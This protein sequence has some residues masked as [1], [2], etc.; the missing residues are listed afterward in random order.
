MVTALFMEMC[1]NCSGEISHERLEK[2]LPCEKCI[3]EEVVERILDL[4]EEEERE[5]EILRVLSERNKLMK[6]KEF[7]EIQRESREFEDFFE[8]CTGFKPW[9]LQRTWA[10]RILSGK[11]FSIVA[12]TGVGK[13]VFGIV[14]SLFL[15]KRGKKCYLILP[16]KALLEQTQKKI[17]EF[18]EKTKISPDWIVCYSGK[19][20]EKERISSGDYRVL[21]TSSQFLTVN[22]DLIRKGIE[23]FDFI[24]IDDVDAFLK[25][26][27]NVQRSLMLM[28]YT[29][30]EIGLA[31][32]LIYEKR[33][34]IRGGD[35][36]EYL[37][38]EKTREEEIKRTDSVLVV[39]TATGRAKGEGIQ[40]YREMLG[41]EVGSGRET[42]RNL[43]EIYTEL[44][45]D[46]LPEILKILGKG[47]LIFVP[48]DLGVNFSKK[49]LEFL[50]ERGFKVELVHS[51]DI[52]GIEKLERGEV[53]YLIGVA[54]YYG[55]MVRGIDLPQVIRFSLF[56]GVPRFRIS[57]KEEPSLATLFFF[58][59]ISQFLD[60]DVRRR[61]EK[62]ASRLRRM[63]PRIEREEGEG[64]ELLRELHSIISSSLSDEE[65]LRRIENDKFISIKKEGKETYFFIPDFRTYI[66]ASG[67]ASRLFAGGISKGISL[68]MVDDWK[69]FNGLRRS[70]SWIFP[71]SSFKSL[72][73]IGKD[74]LEKILEEVNRDR[75][76]I[77]RI[78]SGESPV[79]GIDLVRSVLLVVES[80]NKART[81]ANFFGR[82]SKRRIGNLVSY[83]VSLG[84]LSLIIVA[85]GGHLFDLGLEG[86]HGVLMQN[87]SFVPVYG[88]IKKCRRCGH[89]F[90]EKNGKC[91]RCSSEEILDSLS[92]LES[93][94]ELAEEVDFVLIGTDP[95]TE[96][97]KI[98]WDIY[99]A[100]SPYTKE[101]RRV[102][103]H[104]VTRR[105]IIKCIRE[106]KEFNLRRVE[107]QLVRRIEDRWIGFELSRE[108]QEKFNNRNLSA[109]RVQT[110]VLGWIIDRYKEYRENKAK[111]TYLALEDGIRMS[112]VG[113]VSGEVARVKEV[114]TEIKEISPKPPFTTDEM[115]RE[116]SEKLGFGAEETMR[117][118]QDLFELA[119][120][121]Y[122]RTD[123]SRISPEGID[124][125]RRYILEELGEEYF[126]GRKWG[127]GGA[128]EGIRP[129]QP[130]DSETLWK[131]VREG[132]ITPVKRITRNHLRLYDLIFRRFISSQMTK[133]KVKLV[134]AK[135]EIDGI[136]GE[137]SGYSE[138]IDEGWAKIYDLGI[139][140]IPELKEGSE[141]KVTWKRTVN[142]SLKP[143]YTQGDVVSLMRSRGIGRPST[144]SKIIRTLLERRYV[145]ENNRRRLIPVKLGM[146]VYGYLIN[147]HKELISEER[148]RELER[149]MD[150]IEEGEIDYREVLS[151]LYREISEEMGSFKPNT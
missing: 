13:S 112:V 68:I 53:D 54:T 1:P 26:S 48:K 139:Q 85:S 90:V 73:E 84:D 113:E 45:L 100:L 17:S 14:M 47:G 89:Q 122:H 12:P 52:S 95:D 20:S 5:A 105:A 19:K 87:G 106:P 99:L 151:E 2:K 69:L 29:E 140:R 108:I 77:S 40:L 110:P 123:S 129:T 16:T 71:E 91:P 143:L 24:F 142:T 7:I 127:E 28:G 43:E 36:E 75:E 104:E 55:V 38:L 93:M 141:L 149:M 109:G 118:A 97:E 10:R 121:T 107:A 41:F 66:Q 125:A 130:L 135:L 78:L 114:E 23:K 59:S 146:E 117:L 144:Y 72:D 138:I 70:V 136:D 80:P 46:R 96:G 86:Y 51:K 31:R 76:I 126:Q 98:A 6:Y 88:P 37:E 15:A 81:I 74:E 8:K 18:I 57:L 60:E 82:P 132:T 150:L 62:I 27:K 33:R 58:Q 11:S 9:S 3:P 79:K 39:S 102:E 64:K 116:A 119:L 147:K 4:E 25:S 137:I 61:G 32:S 92:N 49:V 50:R 134:K 128:H 30:E 44:D 42:I 115:I 94:R 131:L 56:L 145:I 83:E 67:R 63:I 103:Y 124:V 22:F 133:A 111:V 65:V 21:V 101:L 34:A 148:T 35:Y 120:I